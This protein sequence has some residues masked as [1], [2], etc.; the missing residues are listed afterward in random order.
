M[1]TTETKGPGQY[2]LV[3]DPRGGQSTCPLGGDVRIS[4]GRAPTNRIVIHDERASRFHAEVS[5][6]DRGWVVRDLASR[7]GTLLSG[8][9]LVGEA[10]LAPGDVIGIGGTEIV[11]CA[12]DRP[13]SPGDEEPE[14]GRGAACETGSMPTDLEAWHASI[15]LRRSRSRLLDQMQDAAETAPR[16]GR[17]AAELCRLAFA[18]GRADGWQEASRLALET[19]IG[20]TGAPR[21]VVLLPAARSGGDVSRGPDARL[22]PVA[23]V[24]ADEPCESVPAGLRA[25]V[26]GGDEALAVVATGSSAATLSAPVRAA[27]RPIGLLHLEM[28]AGREATGEDLEFVMAVC[29]ALGLAIDNLS[30]REAL[31]KKLARTTHENQ[32]LKQRLAQD[33]RLV[34]SSTALSGILA[35]VRRA[36]A[37]R[38]TILIRG[39]SGTGKELVARMVH[40]ASDRRDGP[41]I[42]MN[43]AALSETLLESELFGHEKGAFTGATERTIGRFEAAHG[44]T[45]VLDEIGEMSP[46][47]QAKFLRVLEGHPFERVGGASRIQVDVRVVAATNRD[48]EEA[49]AAGSFRRDLYFRLKVVEIVVPPLRRRREDIAAI[50]DHFLERFNA[51]TGRRLHGFT[52]AAREAMR[53]YHWPGNVRELRNCVERAVVLAPDDWIDVGDLTLSHLSTPGDSWR[54]AVG[55]AAPFVP[56]TLAE[57][58]RRHV[59]ATLEAV[60]NNKTKAAAILD[61]ERS[62]LERKLARWARG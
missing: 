59:L 51:E 48:L 38:A 36:A 2:L 3:R 52:P 58:E 13:T 6:T 8:A 57:V 47:I 40:D 44:G 15:T 23:A 1:A 49:V 34:G 53:S 12:G 28:P 18:L 54:A 43:C 27:G 22:E 24:P 45:L 61:I 5:P 35:Q 20:R 41:C 39:E 19:A 50:A 26:I 42:C 11:F 62:T 31:S 37:T 32:G 14:S 60:G 46:A 55:P 4:L 7:N 17:A 56:T 16:V 10:L 9:P 29:D 33:D 25:A 21:G 30:T